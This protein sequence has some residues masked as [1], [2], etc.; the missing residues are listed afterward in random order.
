VKG[1]TYEPCLLCVCVCVC[2]AGTIDYTWL[3][4]KDDRR[5]LVCIREFVLNNEVKK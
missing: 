4:I 1:K 3:D 2:P 5:N